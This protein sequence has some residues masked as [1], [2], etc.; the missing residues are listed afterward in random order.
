MSRKNEKKLIL[1]FLRSPTELHA[2][3]NHINGVTLQ[4]MKL[5]GE[6]KSQRAVPSDSPDESALRDYKCDVLVKSIGY[7]SLAM[8]GVPFDQKRSVIPHEFGCV[9]DPDSGKLELGLYVA[10]WI[11]RG[12]VGIIDATLRDSME[13]FRMLKHHL[14]TD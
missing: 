11:K 12:P 13:T 1:R 2:T 3:D 4:R 5:E 14:E 10:G 8:S 9:K 7:R 6:P